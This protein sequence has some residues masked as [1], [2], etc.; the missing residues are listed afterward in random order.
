MM[1]YIYKYMEWYHL[2]NLDY[3]QAQAEPLR[4][5]MNKLN[6]FP[7]SMAFDYATAEQNVAYHKTRLARY[8]GLIG[9]PPIR[10]GVV[11]TDLVAGKLEGNIVQHPGDK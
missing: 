4:V 5:I 3:W 2:R 7:V 1:F 8:Q 9:L 10:C 6:E 11:E